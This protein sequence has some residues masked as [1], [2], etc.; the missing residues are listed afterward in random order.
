MK[1]QIICKDCGFEFVRT[2][3]KP[4][5]K[6]KRAPLCPVCMEYRWKKRRSLNKRIAKFRKNKREV[7]KNV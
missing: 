5:S 3:S 7:N 1:K 2:V 4:K 6:K